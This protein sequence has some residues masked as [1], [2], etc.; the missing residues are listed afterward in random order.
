M[1]GSFIYF[2]MGVV[3]RNIVSFLFSLF[4]VNYTYFVFKRIKRNKM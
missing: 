1:T 4:K 3:G 2:V